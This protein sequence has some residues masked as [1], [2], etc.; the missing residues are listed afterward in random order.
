MD[1]LVYSTKAKYIYI[2]RDGRDVLWSLYN[3]HSMADAAMYEALNNSPGQVGRSGLTCAP[4]G[5]SGICRPNLLMVHFDVL[6]RQMPE[7]MTREKLG[8]DCARWL[9]PGEGL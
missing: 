1:A 9:A 6:K 3:H 8:P 5:R 2:G 7:E 4:D